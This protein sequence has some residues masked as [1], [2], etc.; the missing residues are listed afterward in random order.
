MTIF[1]YK[2]PQ[3]GSCV[4][5]LQGIERMPTEDK[6]AL[7]RSISDDL[8]ALLMCIGQHVEAGNL[9]A[10]STAPMDEVIR[11]IRDTEVE[12]RQSLEREL[13]RSRKQ[14]RW[15]RKEYGGVVTGSEVLART[16]RSKV[17]TL[18][19]VIRG[20]RMEVERLTSELETLRLKDGNEGQGEQVDVKTLE[21]DC[22]LSKEVVEK[23][24]G[25]E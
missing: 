9:D 10:K 6:T 11:M 22:V 4:M 3:A 25:E 19:G 23:T 13:R 2:T 21:G 20:L 15:L 17:Q 5:R 1:A 7:L 8:R 18:R 12:Y 16:Y 24:E 14:K